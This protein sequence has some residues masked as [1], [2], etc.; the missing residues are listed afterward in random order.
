MAVVNGQS[1]NG[2]L[3]DGMRHAL[4]VV[5]LNY[6]TPAETIAAVAAVRRMAS[7]S[8]GILL[9]DNASNDGSVERFQAEL[10][11][12]SV[13]VAERNG[14]FSAGCNLGI[15]EALRQGADRVLLL[16]SDAVVTPDMLDTL[17]RALDEHPH[18]GIVGPLVVSGNRVESAGIAYG[19][20]GRMRHASYGV[21]ASALAPF[22]I[23]VVDGVSGCAMLIRKDVFDRVGLLTEEF[24][25]GF[26]DL[27]FCLRARDAGFQTACVGTAVVDHKGNTSIGRISARR[28]Y[29]ASRNHL[30]LA[31][32]R[33][34]GQGAMRRWSEAAWIVALNVAHAA[35]TSDVP[36]IA[37][38]KA[39]IRGTRDHIARRYGAAP[40]DLA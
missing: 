33:A 12:V 22:G 29:F 9:V 23:R 14:G 28:I 4:R 17:G 31:S 32:R 25:F 18:L 38:L 40:D 6:R 2:A 7:G 16:N 20:S 24:F 10:P 5:I 36:R 13:I 35:F 8:T 3:A 1:G 26:E 21:A 39:A 27:E 34:G 19:R 11:D 15:A 37:G 30:L